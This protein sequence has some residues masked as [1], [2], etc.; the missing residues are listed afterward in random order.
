MKK[1]LLVAALVLFVLGL[2]ACKKDE[3]TKTTT[4]EPTTTT[5]EGTVSE[6]TGGSKMPDRPFI[7]S[8]QQ[9]VGSIDPAKAMDETELISVL[10]FY[11]PLYFPE[12]TGGSMKPVPHLAESH[13]VTEDGKTYTFKLKDGIKFHSGNPFTSA[14][15]AYSM[16]RMLAIKQGNSWLWSSIIDDNSI[17]TPDERT[18]IFRLKEP[19]APFIASMTQLFI[20]DSKLVQENEED[21]DFGEAYL[22]NTEAGSGPYMLKAWDRE[23]QIEFTAFEDYWKGWTEGQVKEAQMKFIPEEATTKTLLVSGQVDIVHMYLNP[24]T[25]EEFKGVDGIVVQEDPSAMIQEM[26]MNTQK[27]PT[28]DI[29]VRK[30]IASAFDY[31]TATEQILRG[32]LKGAGPVPQNV[33][34]HS[35]NVTVFER[36]I[37]RAKE[38]LVQSKYVGQPIKVDFMFLSDQPDQKQ[39]A[40]LLTANLKE[41]GIEV[42]LLPSTWPQVTE[43]TANPQT[44]ANLTMISDTL[45]YPHV[46]SHT[47]GKYHPSTHGSYRSAS[48]LDDPEV[49]KTLEEARAAVDPSEQLKLYQKAQDLIT[50]LAPAIFIDDA[51]HRIAYRDYVKGYE[52]VPLMGYDI[53]F[54]YFNVE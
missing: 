9:V 32:A 50:A 30:A 15:V 44:E 36:D 43:A 28:D 11:D 46:D 21:G 54:Y 34:G 19:Y 35:P 45:K 52:F 41:I 51:T 2:T 12:R 20:V 10:N 8:A 48:W 14:D 37:E 3:E 40:Q 26:P 5:S 4:T 7:Y 16:K 47:Y 31:D 27:A 49:T 53:A 23:A 18:I 33:E 25:F 24:M 6:G 39:Y 42:N 22:T 38:Y 29:N 17:E 1:K 13:E